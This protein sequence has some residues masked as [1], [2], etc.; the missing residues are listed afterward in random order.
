MEELLISPAFLALLFF[1]VATVYSSVGLGG[2]TSYTA[3]L[4]VV[5]ASHR[6]IPPVSLTLNVVV[7]LIATVNFIRAGHGRLRLIAPI[8]GTSAPMAYLGGRLSIDA[9]LFYPLLIAVLL[10]VA[11]RV[12]LWSDKKVQRDWNHAFSLAIA[13]GLG[14]SI[15]LLSG[16]VGIGGGIFIGPLIVIL[17]L[18]DAKEAAGTAVVFVLINSI[19]GLGGHLH[20]YAPDWTAVLPLVAAV[21]SGALLGSYLGAI[22]W[23]RST[24]RRVMGF[25]VLAA[26]VL[27]GI[28]TFL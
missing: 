28:R 19:A 3:L 13:V 10:L 9:E 24:V 14:A 11:A 7:S 8:V 1:G 20:H 6:A 26:A 4:A 2:G 25:I 16:M 12:F 17:G 5:G 22:R 23:N 15:G 18:G 21:V 27:I